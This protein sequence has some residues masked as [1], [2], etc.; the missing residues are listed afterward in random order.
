VTITLPLGDGSKLPSPSVDGAFN[1]T[2]YKEGDALTN[3]EIVR[4]TARSADTLTVTRG[5]EGTL[6]TAKTA[7][8]I[9]RVVMFPTAKMISDI[10]TALESGVA[11]DIVN[12]LTSTDTDKA[13]SAAQGKVL[14]DTKEPADA[15]IL[16]EADIVDNLTSTS[17]TAPLSANQGKV[18]QDGKE[19]ADATILK[20]AN[21]VDNLTSTSTTAPL[22]AAQGK[23]L[24][25]NKITTNT[26]TQ[27]SSL[28]V[29]TTASGTAGEIRATNNITAYFSDDR[30]K[31]RFENIS[32]ALD[33]VV[34]L[35]GFY[36][37]E[38]E[39]AKSLGYTN[40]KIQIGVSAQE[41]KAILPEIVI[42][43]PINAN[44]DGADY[45]TVQYDKLVP[46]LIEAIKEL[47]KEV[48]LLKNR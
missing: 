24:Q 37:T 42:D 41:V 21:I 20:Q 40:D 48:E 9:Y 11:V 12:N 16:K 2:I 23:A 22:S 18:L 10:N 7:G 4:V 32:N 3:P 5:Q 38:N 43:A 25:D 39:V 8:S 19:P 13:L 26:N 44:I 30:L 47:Q 36:F 6:A 27:I 46:L 31:T 45:Q 17:I 29:G 28:G 14:Q 35:N 34:S 1:L 33:K 15:T